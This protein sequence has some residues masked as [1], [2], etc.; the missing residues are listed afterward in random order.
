M[1]G[2]SQYWPNLRRSWEYWPIGRA[3][4]WMPKD[5]VVR[6]GK[7]IGVWR[8]GVGRTCL[9]SISVF[10]LGCPTWESGDRLLLQTSPSSVIDINWTLG[11]P[12]LDCPNKSRS[13]DPVPPRLR[14][15]MSWMPISHN[16]DIATTPLTLTTYAAG[17]TIMNIGPIGESTCYFVSTS[18]GTS[19]QQPTVALAGFVVV[20]LLVMV[21]MKVWALPAVYAFRRKI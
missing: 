15:P 5:E 10:R 13:E 12:I 7:W 3:L 14:A 21:E 4:R 17:N 8:G 16:N 18:P 19:I 1:T 20:P 9:E 6:I 2:I 11:D